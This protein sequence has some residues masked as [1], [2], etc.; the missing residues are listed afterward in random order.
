MLAVSGKL[1]R[2]AGG[3]PVDI[4]KAPF[5]GRRT[6]YGFI[7]RQNLP[8]VFRSFDLA[9]PDTSTPQR[10]VTTVPQ[11]ALFLMNSAFVAEQAKALAARPDV[12][13]RTAPEER[14]RHLVRLLFGRDPDADEVT[15]GGQFVASAEEIRKLKGWEQYARCCCC[16]TSSPSLIEVVPWMQKC[17]PRSPCWASSA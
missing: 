8:G 12:L 7:D 11:Q 10:H 1:D 5:S 17:L 15:L 9:S 13:A 6:V 4:L 2:N 3:A 14:V 16:R